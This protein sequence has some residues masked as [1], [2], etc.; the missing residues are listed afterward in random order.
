MESST[1][2]IISKSRYSDIG[3]L[4]AIYQISYSIYYYKTIINCFENHSPNTFEICNMEHTVYGRKYEIKS[5]KDIC[6]C[7]HNKRIG[8]KSCKE[9]FIKSGKSLLR[10]FYALYP[11]KNYFPF[12]K[13]M[14]RP[15]LGIH[16]K[17]LFML[18]KFITSI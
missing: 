4:F 13:C 1:E 11:D 10:L 6:I 14:D 5:D 12:Y 17:K 3:E 16:D 15:Y 18:G 9:I 2:N 8:C 7:R